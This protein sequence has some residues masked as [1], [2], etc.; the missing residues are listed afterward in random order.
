MQ[1]LTA[2]WAGGVLGWANLQS[3]SAL[4]GHTAAGGCSQPHPE[5]ARAG[6]VTATGA[7]ADE[8]H[9]LAMCAAE[10]PSARVLVEL[11]PSGEA[12]EVTAAELAERGTTRAAAAAA[13]DRGAEQ[14]RQRHQDGSGGRS[15]RDERDRER[16]RDREYGSSRGSRGA[17]GPSSRDR[18]RDRGHDRDRDRDRADRDRQR[19][20]GRSGSKQREA[21]VLPRHKLWVASLIRVRIVDKRSGGGKL[22]LKKGTVVDVR[23]DG[24]ADVR[25]EEEGR[26]VVTVHQD[27]LETVV[28]KEPG[29]AVMVVAGEHK[30]RKG[31]LLRAS[32]SN[33]AAALQLL[34]DME[35]VRVLLDDV[36]QF[37]G[38]LD[39]EDE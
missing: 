38:H 19:H 12:V 14:Q 37:M 4:L 22:Y 39:D 3:T 35:V 16:N 28:P 10:G 6:T 36:A 7:V 5:T 33:G 30:G 29:A 26:G 23:P 13:A 34:G 32:T 8:H 25:L 31:R 1:G 11:K 17:E 21:Q 15:S 20:D 9:V 24:G 2:H 18:D 27:Q